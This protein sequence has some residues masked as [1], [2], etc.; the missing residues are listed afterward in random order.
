MS[1]ETCVEVG[2]Q[3]T[4]ALEIARIGW[5]RL[6]LCWSHVSGVAE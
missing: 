3:V 5:W 2:D 4:A 6:F 1:G